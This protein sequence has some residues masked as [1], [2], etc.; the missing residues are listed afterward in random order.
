MSGTAPDT[1]LVLF[2][3]N[4]HGEDLIGARIAAALLRRRPEVDLAALPLVGL[5]EPYAGS[6]VRLLGPR[7]V[8]PSGGLLLHG[9]PLLLADL[10]A[11]FLSL[12]AGQLSSLLGRRATVLVVVGDV[13][14]QLLA[15]LVRAPARFVVQTLVSAH[16]SQGV[17][18]SSP[19]RVFMERITL[20]ERLLMRRWAKVIYV[21]DALTEA[22][23]HSAGLEHARYLGNPIADSLAGSPPAGAEGE[24]RVVALLPGTR[25]Y[26]GR[27]LAIML[28]GLERLPGALGL[29]AWAGGELQPPA[30]WQ[31]TA[32]VSP[33][34]GLILELQKGP[35][36]VLIYRDR[37]A[38]VLSAARLV[39]GTSGTGN[40]QAVALG[41]PVVAFPVP[42]HYSSAFLANQKRL[43]GPALAV[44][45]GEPEPLAAAVHHWLDD[46]ATAEQAGRQG[47]ARIGEPGGSEA[48]AGDIV[49]R[50]EAAGLL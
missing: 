10:R 16:H 25:E 14:A 12:T 18:Y 31:A 2:V 15:G 19:N 50:L 39:I 22:A 7:R 45:P 21:R 28:A 8:L 36:R 38:D 46:P 5:G 48:I 9:L 40:E 23:L 43:L 29:V 6:G 44:V 30:D 37:F 11:G 13:Y 41:L 26:A 4:G 20:P 49:L 47:R 17:V 3:S 32:P 35:T 33:D 34:K 27:A 42:P 1:P 24:R